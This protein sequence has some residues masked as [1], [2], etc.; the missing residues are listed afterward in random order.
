M[1]RRR[2]LLLVV[3]VAVATALVFWL[4]A[5]MQDDTD[6]T[7]QTAVVVGDLPDSVGDWSTPQLENAAIIV[8]AGIDL[9]FDERDRT[10]AVMTAMGESSLTVLDHGDDVGPDSRGL[11]QQRGPWG[12]YA[13]RMDAYG[14]AVLFYQAL[15]EVEDRDDMTP[16]I[17]AHTV[18]VNADPQ[19][20]A[21]YWDDAVLVV[22]AL[23]EAE[24]EVVV[25]SVE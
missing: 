13:V 6:P 14:S 24:F 19:H 16:T 12:P 25:S 4:A 17:V 18:Q 23:D 11:F 15:G 1:E 7:Q 20:Y 9:G 21:P 22:D 5:A 3:A 2:Q 10:I 8:Q